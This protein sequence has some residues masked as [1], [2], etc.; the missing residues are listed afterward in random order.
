ML[1]LLLAAALPASVDLSAQFS[2]E[3]RLQG[4]PG[5]CHAFAAVG[6]FE[7][8]YWRSE[9]RRVRLSE[10]DLFARKTVAGGWMF[11]RKREG[12]FLIEDL[13]FAR[14][15]G[16]AQGDGY[17]EFLPRFVAFRDTWSKAW[18]TPGSVLFELL[19]E[20]LTP[21]AKKS[22]AESKAWM[23]QL[24]IK[25]TG[26]ARYAS[27]T[28]R[29]L[30]T[31]KQVTCSKEEKDRRRAALMGPLAEGLPVAVGLVRH[32]ASS[33]WRDEPGEW[34]GLHYFIVKGYETGPAGV[35][36]KTRN[37][38]GAGKNW[39]LEDEDLCALFEVTYVK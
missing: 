23:S 34:R 6:L 29:A 39:D 28:L 32:G 22:R 36:F 3:E 27:T 31:G 11:A 7:A 33:P 8:A 9:K 25:T 4:E 35:A 17:A 37:T 15:Q 12:G 10:A 2:K 26:V 18:R 20:A 38:Q 21:Q 16:I 1:A 14:K 19:P 24:K 13:L 5:S 30:F